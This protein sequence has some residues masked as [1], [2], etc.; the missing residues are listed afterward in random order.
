MQLSTPVVSVPYGK[1]Q[2]GFG[3]CLLSGYFLW[4]RL[5]LLGAVFV[6][7]RFLMYILI[8]MARWICF[9]VL[10]CPFSFELNGG[11]LDRLSLGKF[12]MGD[13]EGGQCGMIFL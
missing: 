5:Y 11:G 7:V 2:L 8:F 13:E 4:K 12:G 6:E 10:F 3:I 9:S 1:K